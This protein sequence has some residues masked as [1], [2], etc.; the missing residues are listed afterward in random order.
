MK[1]S[2]KRILAITGIG[3]GVAAPVAFG[4]WYLIK[5]LTEKKQGT[6]GVGPLQEFDFA[7]KDSFGNVVDDKQIDGIKISQ[8]K[9][10][11]PDGS[12]DYYLNQEGINYFVK[13]FFETG[14]FGPEV[15]NLKRIWIANNF[16][17]SSNENGLY[18][19]QTNEIGLNAVND[20]VR[21]QG[22]GRISWHPELLGDQKLRAE[23]L[24]QTFAHEYGHHFAYSYFSSPYRADKFDID[25]KPGIVYGDNKELNY[26]NPNFL[27]TFKDDL[28]YNVNK[29]SKNPITNTQ[30]EIKG[31]GV[32]TF[33][34]GEKYQSK[35][36][37]DNANNEV[38]NFDIPANT[39]YNW[40]YLPKNS[41]E[42][43]FQNFTYVNNV[44]SL[45]YYYSQEELYTR[46]TL[47]MT[48]TLDAETFDNLAKN[49]IRSDIFE[50][51]EK[52]QT[53]SA[54]LKNNYPISKIDNVKINQVPEG[55]K[56]L[57][58]DPF[59]TL[60]SSTKTASQ[61]IVENINKQIGHE[62][63]ADISV[64]WNRNDYTVN[65]SS[66]IASPV[67]PAEFKN[68]IKFGGYINNKDFTDVGYKGAD[69]V[70][71]SISKIDVVPFNLGYKT[72]AFASKRTSVA[73]ESYFYAT[74]KFINKNS[75]PI[76]LNKP[77]YFA[78][79]IKDINGNLSWINQ[80]P[81]TS[82]RG[83]SESEMKKIG[84]ASNYLEHLPNLVRTQ[85]KINSYEY[86]VPSYSGSNLVTLKKEY[87]P[88]EWGGA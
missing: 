48:T 27:K 68:E 11:M 39:I 4:T 71:Q 12:W 15:F 34:I 44:N 59:D 81:L 5:F 42:P 82:F 46:K 26:W 63:G 56:F 37:W 83:Q 19:P 23:L 22:D 72:M 41:V 16:L 43:F 20:A 6:E 54:Y 51:Q 57:F 61:D 14:V 2:S 28:H 3:V 67:D 66:T 64:I 36:L 78:T 17:T 1:I 21:L 74:K 52:I 33:C 76:T 38:S 35:E 8:Y 49:R 18:A 84:L 73:G 31:S 60:P 85:D 70:F 13:R 50:E 24:F 53:N 77:L 25:G 10:K 7:Q 80:T 88:A 55:N 65:S 9:T 69:G 45:K 47:L 29:Y 75:I 40:W 30:G 87:N 62:S 86:I 32:T 79:E 58:D